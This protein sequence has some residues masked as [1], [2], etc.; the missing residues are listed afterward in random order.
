MSVTSTSSRVRT[1]RPVASRITSGSCVRSANDR[2]AS[3]SRRLSS[4]SGRLPRRATMLCIPSVTASSLPS[5]SSPFSSSMTP[6]KATAWGTCP[7]STSVT[8]FVPSAI[9]RAVVRSD[10]SASS[11]A[12][13]SS[14]EAPAMRD[15][16]SANWSCR[17]EI[18]HASSRRVSRKRFRST[19][20]SSFAPGAAL[21]RERVTT[22]S[23]VAPSPLSSTVATRSDC[24][25]MHCM[26]TSRR[27][28]R[29]SASRASMVRKS[30]A[31]SADPSAYAA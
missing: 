13:R 2:A 24:S 19:T 3:A 22:A 28:R 23:T 21:Q 4:R 16:S 11:S 30:S 6:S 20:T 27:I 14:A 18:F 8:A 1:R 25:R 15:A 26:V 5:R 9:P 12:R 10:G 29:P 7:R 31:A 17:A